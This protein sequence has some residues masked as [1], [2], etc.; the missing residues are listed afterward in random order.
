MKKITKNEIT[1]KYN[2][3]IEA[4]GRAVARYEYSEAF[5]T[6]TVQAD[7]AA[8]EEADAIRMYWRNQY[9]KI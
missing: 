5:Q 2:K 9:A 6:E 4:Y 7:Y 3:A 1:D 8:M